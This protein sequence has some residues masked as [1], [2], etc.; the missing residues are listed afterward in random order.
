M[1][2]KLIGEFLNYGVA[3]LMIITLLVFIRFLIVYINK[4]DTNHSQER[5]D[6]KKESNRHVEKFAEVVEKSTEALTTMNGKIKGHH[7]TLK[8]IE[9][10]I[11]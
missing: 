1:T 6:W 5:E 3:G 4:L 11:S 2:D 8:R 9:D 7:D 10:K